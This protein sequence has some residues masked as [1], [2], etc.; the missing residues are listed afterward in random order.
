MYWGGRGSYELPSLNNSYDPQVYKIWK[1]NK[2]VSMQKTHLI[3]T[4]G[5]LQALLMTLKVMEYHLEAYLKV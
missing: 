2:D 4:P 3:W 1:R 5:H